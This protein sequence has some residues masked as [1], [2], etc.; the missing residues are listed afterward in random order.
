M[1]FRRHLRKDPNL[2]KFTTSIKNRRRE[3]HF[4]VISTGRPRMRDE[5][6]HHSLGALENLQQK[7]S[8]DFAFPQNIVRLFVLRYRLYLQA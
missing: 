7:A 5:N 8:I 6:V 1:N 3:L 4:K 2:S